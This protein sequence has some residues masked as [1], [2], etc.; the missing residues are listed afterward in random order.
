MRGRIDL[1]SYDW[2]VR[3]QDVVQVGGLGNLIAA[4]LQGRA[5]RRGAMVSST[6]RPWNRTR[7]SGPTCPASAG[8]PRREVDRLARRLGQAAVGAEVNRPRS[9]TST[10]IAVQPSAVLRAEL[11]AT[12]TVEAA[13]LPA[14]LLATLRHAASMPYLVFDERQRRRA[15][16]W[17]TP[18][19]RR[20][21]DE[22]LTGDLLLPRGLQNRLTALVDRHPPGARR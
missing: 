17:D 9:P 10:Q 20:N 21:Y 2:L 3:S 7:T 1:A 5:H 6:W 13:E 18:R 12:I 11:G 8:S 19:F 22:T 15:S 16:T 4:P 14:P